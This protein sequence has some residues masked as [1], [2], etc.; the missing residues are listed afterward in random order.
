MR[1]EAAAVLAEELL[2][3]VQS[4]AAAVLTSAAVI[5]VMADRG[6]QIAVAL[7]QQD[8]QLCSGQCLKA[9]LSEDLV[10]VVRVDIV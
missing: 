7:K 1:P 8:A 4:L 5:V 3:D 2:T 9:E 10:I 6:K